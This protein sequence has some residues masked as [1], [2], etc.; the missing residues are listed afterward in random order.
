LFQCLFYP[1]AL[2]GGGQLTLR[3]GTHDPHSPQ[4]H[5]LAWVWLPALEAYGFRCELHL[6][7]A[8]FYP[9]GGGEFR[10]TLRA[11]EA[12]PA[13]VD[14]PSRGTLQEVEVA[15]FAGGLPLESADRSARA[16]ISALREQGIHADAEN[17][18]LPISLSRGTALL[19]RSH[20]E[21]SFA[22]F[23]AIGEKGKPSEDV[24][25][26]AA[27]LMAEFMERGGAL[28]PHLADQL[29][30]PAALL[31]AGKLAGG[32]PGATRFTTSTC[33]SHLTTNAEILRRFLPIRI[34]IQGTEVTVS[35]GE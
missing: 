18:P 8:G 20:F 3:G 30:I 34:D 1:L 14:L 9:Q 13:R 17:L 4:Y 16:A 24:G 19:I 11:P 6:K 23:S 32:S 31:A 22:G 35:P 15:S 10:G 5:Y 25:R 33:T 28:D 21:N 7:T 12:A 27:S 29:L 26:E 2:A